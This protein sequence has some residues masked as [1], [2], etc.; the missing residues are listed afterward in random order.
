MRRAARVVL[1]TAFLA[2]GVGSA[3]AQNPHPPWPRTEAIQLRFGAFFLEGGGELWDSNEEVFTLDASDFDDF[4]F[5]LSWVHS[6]TN[7]VELGVNLDF[8]GETVLSQYRDYV[9]SDGFRIYH[10]TSLD[11]V[12]LTADVRFLVGGRH[13][14]RAKGRRVVKPV[15]Y[16]G[17]G[18]GAIFWDYEERGDFLDFTEDPL[19]IF[20]GRFQDD[21]SAL[22]IHALAGVELPMGR[23]TSFLLEARYSKADDDL[24]GDFSGLGEIELGGTAVYGGF[25]FRF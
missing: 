18:I 24:G 1:A 3:G 17:G 4:I 22:E 20:P 25:S 13:R 2:V 9:D 19:V 12:P 14:I 16:V 23:A 6:F 11:L 15:F 7:H 8:Y 21:G 5:G 10:D